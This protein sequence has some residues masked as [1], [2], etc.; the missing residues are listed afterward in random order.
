MSTEPVSYTHLDVY[1]RQ[2]LYY[3]KPLGIDHVAIQMDDGFI[4]RFLIGVS[5]SQNLT[6]TGLSALTTRS[7]FFI[8]QLRTSTMSHASPLFQFPFRTCHGLVPL[9]YIEW[10]IFIENYYL[11]NY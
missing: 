5:L 4:P 10:F 7:E 9:C 8:A 6:R 3:T 1:K 2:T 11:E